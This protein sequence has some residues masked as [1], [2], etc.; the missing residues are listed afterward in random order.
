MMLK[1]RAERLQAA[2]LDL[3]AGRRARSQGAFS[4]A[5]IFL[6]AGLSFLHASERPVAEDAISCV[7]TWISSC[8]G[9]FTD[10]A[11][12][13]R[14]STAVRSD[15][16][17][18]RS[19]AGA[20]THTRR[21]RAAL[22]HPDIRPEVREEVLGRC[23]GRAG[24]PGAAGRVVPVQS[25]RFPHR[26]GFPHDAAPAIAEADLKLASMK[27]M[28]SSN[29]KAVARII[30]SVYPAAYLGR[31]KLFPLLVYRH[32]NDSIRHGN[33]D[34]SAVT[35]NAFAV[36]LCA[37][38]QFDE[39]FRLADVGLE[40]LKRY[41]ARTAEQLKARVFSIYYFLIFPW[42]HHLRDAIPYYLVGIKSGLE[43]GD[44]EFAS[45]LVHLP[46]AGPVSQPVPLSVSYR[47][48]WDAISTRSPPWARSGRSSCRRSCVRSS[49]TCG[50]ETPGRVLS[51]PDYVEARAAPALSAPPRP[52]SGLSQPFRQ[53]DRQRPPRQL[54]CCAC[55]GNRGPPAPGGGLRGLS[56][57]HLRLLRVAGMVGFAPIQ[58]DA[59][60]TAS[61]PEEES[62][63]V[64][65]DGPFEHP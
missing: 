37:L 58:A 27:P 33:E 52:E 10:W 40:L 57:A 13:W 48:S 1:D 6:R 14:W 24:H 39:G 50:S 32:V 26:L 15:E 65:G 36:V 49:E 12:R 64:S 23:R 11:P 8:P 7:E 16:P 46:G 41:E 59:G 43:H 53:A 20:R 61:P 34:Y 9:R 28:V 2:T 62:T 38:G 21:S 42:S 29:V 31:P 44:F 60:R 17:P 47:R 51:G 19:A 4:Q 54:R 45:Y 35:Y 18:L 30:Q 5:L 3:N 22:R 55:G 25:P 63:A 56:R